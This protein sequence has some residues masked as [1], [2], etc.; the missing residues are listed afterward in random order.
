MSPRSSS[1][2]QELRYRQI[3]ESDELGLRLAQIQDALLALPDDAFAEKYELRKERDRLRDEAA[4]HA[5][6]LETQRSDADLLAELG[7]LRQQLAVLNR[8]KIDLVSQAGGGSGTGEMGNLGGTN[9]N[10][11]M[12]QASGADQIQARI[13]RII[14]ILTDRGVEIPD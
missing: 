12:M 2:E 9:I 10:L 14:G 8:Q 11:R 5:G 7:A 3:M 1:Q 6:E 13:G 4:G